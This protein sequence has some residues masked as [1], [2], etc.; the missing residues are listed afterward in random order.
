MLFY[1]WGVLRG[2]KESCLQQMPESV[3]QYCAPQDIPQP[4]MS[5]PEN[6]CSLRPITENTSEEANP[7]VEVPASEET[8]SLL[9]SRVVKKD[10]NT[11]GPSLVQLE[12][13]LNSSSSHVVLSDGTNQVFFFLLHINYLIV[14]DYR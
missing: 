12:H 2:K 5:L 4:I 1:L 11:G 7:V 3:N 13:G 9:T 6:R 8:R 14:F 10:C